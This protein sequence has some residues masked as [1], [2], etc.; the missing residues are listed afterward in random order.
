[1]TITS[2]VIDTFNTDGGT[3][4]FYRKSLAVLSPAALQKNETMTLSV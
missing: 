4:L 3:S 2:G 1:M